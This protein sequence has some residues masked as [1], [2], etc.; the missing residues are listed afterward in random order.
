MADT[1]GFGR[2]VIVV[3]VLALLVGSADVARL[4]TYDDREPAPQT[5]RPV[6]LP[7][8]ATPTTAASPPPTVIAAPTAPAPDHSSGAVA[9]AGAT[10]V[11]PDLP[12]VPAAPTSTVPEAE[13]N[14]GSDLTLANSPDTPYN[15]LC[16]Q[17]D[18]PVTW[19]DDAIRLF[20]S[21]LTAD[22]SAGLQLALPQWEQQ[23]RFRVTQVD[24]AS[25][26]N[27]TVTTAVLDNAE[28]GHALVHYSCLVTCAFDHVTIELSST[29]ELT[30]PLW[31]TTILHELG[32]AAGLNHV[33]RPTQVM[34]PEL[35]ILSPSIYSDGD[36]AGLQ[37]LARLRDSSLP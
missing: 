13:V 10:V 28:D 1:P 23:G 24:S 29:R 2:R 31:I 16:V 14:C 21:G 6:S 27:L 11:E 20:S 30:N 9:N 15:F 35:D 12:A 18:V 37:E 4:L 32:H 22:Q 3:L 36:V 33:S 25:A 26:A 7:S 5:A 8:P 34:Y 17:G 19:P